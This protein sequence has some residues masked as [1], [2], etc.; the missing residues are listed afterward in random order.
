VATYPVFDA[1]HEA[2]FAL[3]GRILADALGA[4]S[5]ASRLD[6]ARQFVATR[7]ERLRRLPTEF[8]EFDRAS[9]MNEGLAEYVLVRVLELVAADREVPAAWR[10]AAS[11]KL[12]A[13]PEEVRNLTADSGLSFRLRYYHTGPA[14]ARLLDA[15][16][17]DWKAR[18]VGDNLWL[19]DVLADAT[20]IDDAQRAAFR[21]AVARFDSAAAARQ[22]AGNIASLQRRRRQQVDSIMDAPGIVLV[23]RADSLP[24]RAFNLCG[25]DPQNLLQVT[26]RIRLQTRWWRPCSG[27]PTYVDLNI[28]SVHD[29]EHGTLTAVIGGED[30]VTVTAGGVAVPLPRPGETLRDLGA[31]KLSAP[32][33]TVEA[34]RADVTRSGRTLTV[35]PRRAP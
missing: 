35:W 5:R 10:A 30:Q 15:L 16:R 12:A 17:P 8:A 28:P 26:E 21:A 33:V 25:F 20:G 23:V 4:R 11:R 27:G 18:F 9:E 34:A 7:R 31:F 32:G 19:E 24:T 29:A 6:L 1:T 2:L 13:R 3:E 14:I 22:A